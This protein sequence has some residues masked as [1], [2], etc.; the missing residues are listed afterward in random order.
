MT[1]FAHERRLCDLYG[2]WLDSQ[3]LPAISADELLLE[4]YVNELQ[5]KWLGRFYRVWDYF[6]DGNQRRRK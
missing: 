2:R 5:A 6:V 4:P 3:G 1:G